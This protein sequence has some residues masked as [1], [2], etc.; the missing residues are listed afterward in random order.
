MNIVAS[1]TERQACIIL[2]SIIILLVSALICSKIVNFIKI[3]RVA[4]EILGGIIVGPTVLGYFF[5]SAYNF[6]FLNFPEQ[7]Q[8][9]SIFYWLGLI[10][11]MATAGYEINFT[12]FKGEK[13]II[14]ALVAGS[15]I[16]PFILGFHISDAYFAKFYLGDAN[17]LLVFHIIFA[18]AVSVTS[19]PVI[20]KIFIDLD[21]IKHKFAKIVLAS[22]TIQDVFL[23][24]ILSIATSM[25]NQQELSVVSI[26]THVFFTVSVFVAALMLPRWL[27][28]SKCIY[29]FA[30]FSYDSI[31]FIICFSV[32]CIGYV[33][34]VNIIYSAFISGII[35]KNIPD[36]GA[37]MTQTKLKDLSL[38][39]FTPVYFAIVGLRIHLTTDFSVGLFISFFLLASLIEMLGCFITLKIVGLKN[40]ISLNFGV[41]MNARG[42]PGIV[43]ASVT[44]EMG[45]INYEFFCV[46]IFTSIISSA[47]AGWWIAFINKKGKLLSSYNEYAQA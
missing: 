39:F 35:F 15:T 17:N 24:I 9:L 34:G 28:T 7:G 33:L 46:L 10:L 11:L 16:L 1:L 37:I 47:M 3:P 25:L 18:I 5:P 45:I 14:T 27:R 8:I 13:R 32:I 12:D 40:L 26:L 23:W 30:I 20:S 4:G 19:L 2:L 31:Y 44:Y 22:A 38:A 29:K 42:G 6:V 41:A 21:L 43:L 36:N